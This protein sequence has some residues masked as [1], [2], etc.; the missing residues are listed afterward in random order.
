MQRGREI[1]S[2]RLGL[3][4]RRGLSTRDPTFRAGNQNNPRLGLSVSVGL[5]S[6]SGEALAGRGTPRA[7]EP[8]S[9]TD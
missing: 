5:F 4:Q 9:G 7:G 2:V 6:F 1:G 3:C 8:N